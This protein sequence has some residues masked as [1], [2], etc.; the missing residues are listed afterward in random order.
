MKEEK[1]ESTQSQ[2]K[3]SK[4]KPVL[5]TLAGVLV[6]GAAA[7]GG[8]YAGLQKGRSE[9]AEVIAGKIT[10]TL[11][12]LNLLS[13]NPIFPG[14]VIGQ[15]TKIESDKI[16]V[17]K[18]NGEEKTIAIASTTQVTKQSETLKVNDVQKDQ[19]VT[20]FVKKDGDKETATRIIVR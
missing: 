1:Q 19:Q 17:K 7:G 8:Y 5:L 13:S 20:V 4:K 10:E 15:V 14:S 3:K 18:A 6:V 16:T 11:N 9:A 2:T 12:P